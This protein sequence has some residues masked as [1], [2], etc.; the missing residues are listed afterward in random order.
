MPS[1]AAGVIIETPPG[2]SLG[3]IAMPVVLPLR[4]VPEPL[5]MVLCEADPVRDPDCEP[6]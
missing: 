3:S 1:V 5:V 4:P 2:G 6:D